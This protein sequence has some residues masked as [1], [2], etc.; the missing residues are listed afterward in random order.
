[1]EHEGY[2]VLLNVCVADRGLAGGGASK[3]QSSRSTVS[4]RGTTGRGFP[5]EDH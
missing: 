5:P 1:M 3:R 2:Y 4:D